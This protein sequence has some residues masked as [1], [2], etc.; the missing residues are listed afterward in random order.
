MKP[1][2]I[3]GMA[4]ME[5]VMMKNKEEYAVAVRKPNNEI[6]VEKSTHKD[7]SDKVKLFK[8]PIFRGMI[9]FVDSMVIGVKVL[10]FSAS[11]FEEEEEKT[12]TDKQRKK[13]EKKKEN[14]AKKSEAD[15]AVEEVSIA[16]TDEAS[17]DNTELQDSTTK[18]NKI[19][20]KSNALLMAL[21]VLI[22]IV[23]SVSLFMVLPVL[24]TNFLSDLI[25][26]RFLIA[27]AEGVVRISIFIGYV[28]LA[29]RMPEIKRVFMYH[30]AEHK[31]INCLENGF[32]LTVENVKWQSKQ[33][34][35]CGTSFM[36][37]VMMISLIF[38]I[39]LPPGNLLWRVLSRV[40]LVPI[41]AGVSYEFIRLAGKSESKLVNI[42]SQPG[43]WMQGLTTKEPDDSMIEVA[44][45]SVGAV[46]DWRVFLET[47]TTA[48]K[49]NG[50]NVTTKNVAA[51]NQTNTK[52]NTNVKNNT[53]AK[54]NTKKQITATA[55][56]SNASNQLSEKKQSTQ[57][58]PE[59]G[60]KQE[61]GKKSEPV[62]KQD[63]IVKLDAAAKQQAAKR[64]NGKKQDIS[65]KQ[66]ASE[67][68]STS[69]AH[70][71]VRKHNTGAAP[72]TFKPTISNRAEEEDDEILKALD[73]FFDDKPKE[74]NK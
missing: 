34:K 32:E 10:N 37:L 35:R 62:V 14:K 31:T 27:L 54:N 70:A 11:F 53:T 8:L 64:E 6:A 60:K 39:I 66:N 65:V 18:E 43:M 4:V 63:N 58:K 13:L 16:H 15:F 59:N 45:A 49:A 20:D 28:L 36:L 17:L 52:N 19:D 41:I 71:E 72:V 46:F 55:K 30:G 61:S 21:A 33:H 42:L 2:G 56:S 69:A 48:E 68:G 38:F 51:T 5:G 1:S 40:I 57:V 7:I 67:Q 24:L 50:K 25:E 12:L 47:S 29:S 73:K 44:I 74:A 9:A 26:N 22:S 23:V 3:G